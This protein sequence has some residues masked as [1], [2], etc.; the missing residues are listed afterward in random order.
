MVNYGNYGADRLSGQY[1]GISAGLVEQGRQRMADDIGHPCGLA[2]HSGADDTVRWVGE[3]EVGGEL[4]LHDFL[5]LRRGDP[6]LGEL[7]L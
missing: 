7:G 6:L 2:G 5:R 3:E 4:G 1:V